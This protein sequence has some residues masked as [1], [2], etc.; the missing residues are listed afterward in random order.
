MTPDEI[1]RL[2]ATA[3]AAA[4]RDGSLT[5]AAAVEAALDR[6]ERIDPSL[7]AFALVD[8]SGAREAAECADAKRASGEALGPLHG[9][10]FS[11][12][13]LIATAGLETAYGSHLMAGNVPDRDA[14]VVARL[15][16][17]GAILIG[18]TTTP[19][20]AHKAITDS[21][22]YG[23]TR[24]PWNPD[25]S[26]GG[27]SGGAAVAVATGMGPLALATDGAG[28]ARIPASCCGVLGIKPTLGRVPNEQAVDLFG[29]FIY[30]GALTRTTADMATM[31]TVMSGPH[32]GDPWT[33]AVAPPPCRMPAD[34][35]A[36]VRGLRLH[37]KPR[38]G[39]RHLD[40]GVA[41][42]MEATLEILADAG[43]SIVRSD[44]TEDWGNDLARTVIRA[45]L[46]ARMARFSEA[47]RERMDPSLRA[48]IAE[49]EALDLR[50]V[51]EAPMRRTALYH[52][53]E[54]VFRDAD[55]LLTPCVSA[56]P[57]RIGHRAT[58]PIVINGEVAGPM[59][60]NW[61]NY[62][63][64]FNLTGH[65]AISIPAR[66]T[67]DGLPIGLQAVGP[68]MGEQRL[69]DLAAALEILQPWPWPPVVPGPTKASPP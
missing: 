18:K 37:Y 24:N 40:D 69:I 59:R 51:Q 16:T 3:T 13:D 44:G 33:R 7:A 67:P 20:F 45:P 27:S 22:R 8:R 11:V 47:E 39:N 5:A 65:P 38:L 54:A 15:K 57:P 1:C 50:A 29:N 53:T 68:W 12:K 46:A 43:A 31:L 9:V 28:S 42:A 41:A 62:P 14:A 63:A 66:F 35:V 58:D 52:Q 10:P 25:F 32:D 49:S 55:L 36:T 48:A 23:A 30:L 61:Y 34:A 26:A 6:I 56:P 60:A 19:E 64:P 21:P 2:P 17:A 4:I